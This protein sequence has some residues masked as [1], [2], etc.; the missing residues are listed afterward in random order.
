MKRLVLAPGELT[1]TSAETI[2]KVLDGDREAF[3][4]LVA[5]HEPAVFG[6]CRKLFRGDADQAEDLTQETFVRAYCCL[7]RLSDRER[8]GPWLYQIARSLFRDRCRRQN[9][10]RRALRVWAEDARRP[11]ES[12]QDSV[13]AD[14]LSPVLADLPQAERR[15]LTLRYFDGLSYKELSERLK[16]SFSQVDH[17]IRK[18]RSRLARRVQVSRERE[19]RAGDWNVGT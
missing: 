17:L 18:A 3:R 10:E 12:S 5:T 7:H 2:A 11:R 14:G 8:F 6:L 15:I 1:E 16:M 9:A 19:S 13:E 4:S